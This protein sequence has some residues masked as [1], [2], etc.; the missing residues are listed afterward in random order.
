V[1]RVVL[2]PNALISALITPRGV[3][4]RILIHLR[5][6][7]FEVVTSPQL[8]A[9]L[10]VVLRR[11]RF[12]K[13]VEPADVDA[14]VALIARESVAHDDPP[15]SGAVL[16]PDPSDEYLIRLARSAKVDALVSGDPHLLTLRGKIPVESPR[17]LVASLEK[18]AP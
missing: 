11:E 3:C 4:A 6:G 14:F 17:E 5:D 12:R 15:A 2:D 18:D 13:Y 8:L 16:G 1:R 9:E 10:D 7:A